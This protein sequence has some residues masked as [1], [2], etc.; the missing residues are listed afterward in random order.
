MTTS[1]LPRASTAAQR[2]LKAWAK[3]T[4]RQKLA[5]M[6]KEDRRRKGTLA[7]SCGLLRQ[8][9]QDSRRRK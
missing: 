4:G 1:A 5:D 3:M 9:S 6:E 2:R 7:D 8:D